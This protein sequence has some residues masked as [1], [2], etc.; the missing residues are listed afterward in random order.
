MTALFYLWLAGVILLFPATVLGVGYGSISLETITL[1]LQI[2]NTAFIFI[3]G[4]YGF[5]QTPVFVDKLV[6]D[7]ISTRTPEYKRSGLSPEQAKTLHARL[8]SIMNDQHP[9]LNGE[10]SAQD[11]SKLLGV[12]VN[13]LSQ[14]LTREQQQ[15]FFDFVNGYRVARVKAK[16]ADPKYRHYT[17]LAIGLESGFNS[18]TAFN[19]T[20]KKVTGQTPSQFY[21][22]I[23]S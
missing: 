9:Y 13:H 2:A 6:D 10:L 21:S 7:S 18:K 22:A 19:T 14:I 16:M 3:A 1:L 17:L 4:Y 15:N 23:K 5:R 20:F 8:L 12:S 11:L